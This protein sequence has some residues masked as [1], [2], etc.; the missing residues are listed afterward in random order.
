MAETAVQ[1]RL[2]D[3]LAQAG[4]LSS[5]YISRALENF[6]ERGLPIGKVLV[7]SGYLTDKQLR[8]ALEVQSL[9]N[10]GLLPLS[11][12]IKALSIALK[13]NVALPEAFKR[14]G[15]VQ[16]ED[17]ETNRLGQLLLEAQVIKQR[18]LDECLET[19]IRTGLPLGRI[20]C[21]R[22]FTSRS[23]IDRA[24]LAQQ[25][26]RRG[27]LDRS[28]A[29]NGLRLAF[30]Q[31]VNLIKQE[32]NQ[33]Y[34]YLPL[35]QS[36]SLGELAVEA[37]TLTAEPLWHALKK[38]QV[39]GKFVGEIL[40]EQ[41]YLDQRIVNAIIEIQEM[42]DNGTFKPEYAGNALVLICAQNIDWC[43]AV[44][45][46]GAFGARS[47]LSVPLIEILTVSG[48]IQLT[49]L[50]GEIQRKLEV[51]YNQVD[52]VCDALLKARLVEPSILYAALR[53][54]FL[55]GEN[56]LNLQ[57]AV[58][59]LDFSLRAKLTIDGAIHALGWTMRTRLRTPVKQHR[60]HSN[61]R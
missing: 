4:I 61:A 9:V 11:M 17:K 26:I 44:A 2:G 5:E 18:D 27:D 34:Q 39:D 58:M 36:M 32:I 59:A 49:K 12:A 19:N 43:Q 22:N 46:I 33:G 37:R 42:L 13:E 29:I 38:S 57:Q 30:K 16:P 53:L 23:F 45:Q 21:F 48:N 20:F 52:D 8:S 7:L 1:L 40:V 60:P 25:L 31:Q 56:I 47:N 35:K 10:D 6:E 24:L 14:S 55:L 41:G 51:N 28:C 15:Y 50:P 3:L 54:V